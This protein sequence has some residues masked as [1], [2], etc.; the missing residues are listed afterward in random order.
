[1][2]SDPGDHKNQFVQSVLN[3]FQSEQILVESY[4]ADKLHY[5]VLSLGS[6]NQNYLS[7]DDNRIQRTFVN[8]FR[9]L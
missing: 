5:I 3:D 7:I 4:I 9:F 1:M 8:I 2:L 6:L